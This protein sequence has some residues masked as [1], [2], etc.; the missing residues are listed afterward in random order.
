MYRLCIDDDDLSKCKGTDP[1]SRI[2]KQTRPLLSSHLEEVCVIKLLQQRSEIPKNCETKL[3]QIK[4]TVWT[5][6]DN[7]AWIYFAPIKESV[8]I[9]C[10]NQDPED[11]M[12]VGVGK[13]ALQAG[14]K[15]YTSVAVLQTSLRI[16]SRDKKG[17]DL[18][19][20]IPIN[21]DCLEELGFHSKLDMATINL[22][23]KHVVSH[24]DDLKHASYKV[25]EL[26]REIK[27]QE[28]RNHQ[29]I[30]HSAYSA[31]TYVLFTLIGMY[32][33][34]KLY[35]LYWYL[36]YRFSKGSR[37]VVVGP[38]WPV[39][40]AAEGEE[41]RG[42]WVAWRYGG[43]LGACRAGGGGGRGG[44]GCVRRYPSV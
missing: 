10:M 33:L 20:H 34:Y 11:V 13:L 43:V 44:G 22:E 30:K 17:E 8:T 39:I 28:W 35:K 40:L 32:I 41:V 6:L 26:D 12:L 25:S 9:L 15:G 27:E 5:Q 14:C 23:F 31:I 24:L 4:N 16:K 2:C 21:V 19:S 7:N 18:L 38:L 36:R 3:V 42:V 37:A 29:R 1:Q